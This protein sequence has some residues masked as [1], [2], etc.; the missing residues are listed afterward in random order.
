M[1]SVS[2]ETKREQFALSSR[3]PSP[4]LLLLGGDSS[5]GRRAL[6]RSA[7]DEEILRTEVKPQFQ[8]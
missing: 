6:T 5:A 3:P 2:R 7:S 1:A 8:F 4:L